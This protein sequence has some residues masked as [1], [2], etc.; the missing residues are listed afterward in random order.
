[1]LTY[2][3]RRLL[4]SIVVLIAASFLVFTFVTVSGNPLAAFETNP[5]VSQ[6]TIDNIRERKHLNENL[7]VRYGYWVKEAFT[8]QFGT[9]LL[10]NQPILPDLWRVMKNTL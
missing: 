2:I 1:M 4:Y 5:N 3:V 10:T 6:Q 9:T 7:V 8:E